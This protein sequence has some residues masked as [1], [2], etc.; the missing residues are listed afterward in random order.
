[1]DYFLKGDT[2]ITRVMGMGRVRQRSGNEYNQN[3]L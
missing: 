2:K 1:L 3:A